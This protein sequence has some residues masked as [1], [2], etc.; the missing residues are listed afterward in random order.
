M[1][2]GLFPPDN[3]CRGPTLAQ[4]RVNLVNLRRGYLRRL[5][6]IR[7][8]HDVSSV[9]DMSTWERQLQ[10][11]GLEVNRPLRTLYFVRIVQKNFFKLAK[12][13]ELHVP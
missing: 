4:C 9:R 12:L 11:D 7:H 5:S 10:S 3:I 13:L 6:N 8:V 2:P 1:F